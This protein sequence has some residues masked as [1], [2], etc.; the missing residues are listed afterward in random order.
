M[1]NRLKLRIARVGQGLAG[2]SAGFIVGLGHVGAGV[3]FTAQKPEMQELL[4]V[5]R[6]QFGALHLVESALVPVTLVLAFFGGRWHKVI[7]STALCCYLVKSLHVQPALHTRMLQRLAGEIVGE[8]NLHIQYFAMSASL[9]GLLTA[10]AFLNSETII[11][12]IPASDSDS[13]N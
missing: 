4:D 13:N 10:L 6:V 11:G 8:S 12:T 5:G 2:I 7:A 9:V 3:K 1:N